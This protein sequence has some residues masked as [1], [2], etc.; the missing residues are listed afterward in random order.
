RVELA[1]LVVLILVLGAGIAFSIRTSNALTSGLRFFAQDAGI[2]APTQQ[3][4]E[5]LRLQAIVSQ[6]A[7]GGAIPAEDYALQRDLVI[8]RIGLSRDM[9]QGNPTLFEQDRALVADLVAAMTAY[10]SI[11][12]GQKPTA[13][14]ARELGPT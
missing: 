12:G 3:E 14:V 4:R 11:E 10:R 13:A 7:L 8:S 6:I 2:W 1:M 9:T 5:I